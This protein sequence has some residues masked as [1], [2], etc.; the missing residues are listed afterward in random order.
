PPSVRAAALMNLALHDIRAGGDLSAAIDRL[1]EHNRI[2]TIPE[3]LHLLGECY[4][5]QDRL[6]QALVPLKDSLH[7]RPDRPAVQDTLAVAYRGLGKQAAADEHFRKAQL[8]ARRGR[9]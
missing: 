1:Q 7:L 5:R 3:S 9:Q 4:L 8:L 2:Y 6:E